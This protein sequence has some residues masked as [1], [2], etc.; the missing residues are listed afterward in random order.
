MSRRARILRW[1]VL[2]LLLGAITTIAVAWALAAWLPQKNWE[3]TMIGSPRDFTDGR[4][5]V[6]F[7]SE[8]RTIGAVRRSW[9]R[10]YPGDT[11][12]HPFIL[13]ID[14]ASNAFESDRSGAPL[15]GPHW[16][17]AESVRDNAL[18]FSGD[19]MEHA[20]GWPVLAAWYCLSEEYLPGRHKLEGGVD[21][22]SGLDAGGFLSDASSYRAL[23]LHPIWPGL[24]IDTA[25]YAALWLLPLG[26]LR[27][28]RRAYRRSRNHCPNC[29]Y[30]LTGIGPSHSRL[31]C[32]ECGSSHRHRTPT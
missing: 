7:L 2:P 5:Y 14:N 19:G 13:A 18:D 25:F 6:L 21:L 15:R 3:K 28:A 30:D 22:K 12:W 8:Y 17:I 26:A 23:P 16:G 29:A 9:A 20:T 11:V 1:L 32:P 4:N 24:L 10:D 31:T 27:T